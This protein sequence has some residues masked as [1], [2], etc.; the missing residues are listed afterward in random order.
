[1]TKY[2]TIRN[3]IIKFL[4]KSNNPKKFSEIKTELHTYDAVIGRELKILTDKKWIIKSNEGYLLNR[5]DSD[6]TQILKYLDIS[7]NK[8]DGINLIPFDA[9]SAKKSLDEDF[10]LTNDEFFELMKSVEI[11]KENFKKMI[12]LTKIYL[13]TEKIDG[14]EN[15]L[16]FAMDKSNI[17]HVTSF[18]VTIALIRAFTK[19]KNKYKEVKKPNT[20]NIIED[21]SAFLQKVNIGIEDFTAALNEPFKIIITFEGID[22]EDET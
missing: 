15:E 21:I 20:G 8:L 10:N 5:N 6:I 11:D 18:L 13:A 17:A 7:A 12:D 4:D 1:M 16:K 14:L 19:A 9:D 3:G 2:S 22:I